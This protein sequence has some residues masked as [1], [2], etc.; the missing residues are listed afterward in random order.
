MNSSSTSRG[1]KSKTLIT[2]AVLC[3][4]IITTGAAPAI[5]VSYDY[6]AEVNQTCAWL[7][8]QQITSGGNLG[9]IEEYEGS[10]T[11]VESDN[12]QEAIWMWSRYA[13]LTGDLT[14]YQTNIDHAWTY[15]NN[16]PAW[17]EGGSITNYYTTYNCAWGMRAEMKYRQVYLGKAGYVDHTAYGRRCASTLHQ[18]NCGT[19]GSDGEA[20]ILGFAAGALYQYGLFDSN[21]VAQADAL[22]FGNTVRTWL[23]GSTSNFSSN[24]WAVSAGV[25]VWG[26]INSY[27][28]DPNHSAEAPAWAETANTYMPASDTGTSDGYQNGHNGWYAWGHYALSEIRGSDSFTKYQSLIDTLLSKDGDNDGGIPQ[29]GSTGSDYAWTT[30]I[31]QTASNMGLVGN[32]YTISGTITSGGSALAGVQMSGLPGAPVT[33]ANGFYTAQVTSGWIGTVTPIKA[34][35]IF[36]PATR[37]YVVVTSNQTSQNYTAAGLPPGQATSPSPGNGATGVSV[38]TDLSWTAGSGATSHDVYF[39]TTSPGTFQGN[40]TT[41]T[42][43]TG[44]MSYN[45]TYYWRIDEKNTSGTT[46]GTVWSFTTA[47]PPSPAFVAVGTVATGTTTMTPALPS[48]IATGDILLLFVETANQAVTISNQNNGTWAQVTNSP[49]GTGT[50]G[51]TVAT[52]LTIFWSRYNGSQG[53]PTTSVTSGDHQIGQIAAFRGTVASGNPWDVTAG[54]VASTASTSVSIPGATTTVANTLVLAIVANGTD[55]TTAQTSGWTNSN[56]T[57]LTELMD[58]STNTGNGGGFGIAT[59]GKA[60]AGTYSTT[61]AT[62]A[63]SS[64][65]GRMSIALKPAT[66]PGQATN[67]TPTNG[68]TNVAVTTDLNWSAG[69]GAST[70]DVYFDTV[71]P[72]VTKV[73]AN[74]TAL[75]YDTGTMAAST[76][77]YWRVDEKN[78][79]GNTTGMVWSFT[80]GIAAPGKATSPSPSSGTTGIGVTTDLS[81]TAGSG[82]TSHDVYFGT[83]SP[84]TFIG[85]Q[86]GTT[87]DTGTMANG[88]TYYWRIDEKNAGGTTTGDV[89][90]FTTIVRRTLTSSSTTGGD[91]TTPGEGAFPYDNGTVASLVAT[92]DAHYHF[93]NWTGTAVTAGKVASPTS[94]STTVTMDADYTVVANF[95]ID[96]FTLGYTAGANGTLTGNTS[97]VVNYGL[98][99][100]R[101]RHFLCKWI[102]CLFDSC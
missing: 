73:I 34:G 5:A 44:T 85:N 91:V 18:G 20:C 37:T 75:T 66:L 8:T 15:L 32:I 63:T 45:T 90:S 46:T 61:T 54:N 101:A 13:E 28:K 11:V 41:T 56:L 96:T 87:F 80:T 24:D 21:T 49:Q 36:T 33:D 62:L 77:Y 68:A 53:A 102:L 12:T 52:S 1:A 64:V 39:G 79:D 92:P 50:A 57:S 6:A 55:T 71:N 83:V 76:T 69:S 31:M 97:Q 82:A 95:A 89:W 86:A 14:K 27:F 9:G 38:T 30:D 10:T 84:G 51:G 40:R 67:P 47:G 60:T 29:Q 17:N 4:L 22:T 2:L 100:L 26:V 3:A 81:W 99:K 42:F 16:F 23:N 19:S 58:N 72:P 70:R 43:D 25:A 74:G 7:V 94:A 98:W 78:A 35:Y 65:Q 88:T 59:G 48:G 93:V